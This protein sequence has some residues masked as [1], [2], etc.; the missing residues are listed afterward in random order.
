MGMRR[1]RR[2]KI[3]GKRNSR[4][5]KRKVNRRHKQPFTNPSLLLNH[6]ANHQPNKLMIDPLFK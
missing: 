4:R 2:S 3:K 1:K 6:N 5:K